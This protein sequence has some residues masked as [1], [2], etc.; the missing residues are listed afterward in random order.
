VVKA[1][2]ENRF[3][4]KEV[5]TLLLDRRG[6][7]V[8]ITEAVVKAAAANEDNNE[9]LRY[10]HHFSAFDIT[11]GII[12]AAATSGQA[13]ALHLLDEWAGTCVVAKRSMDIAQFCAAA[14]RGDTA[15]VL[16]FVKEGIPPDE[17]DI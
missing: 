7:D 6:A 9:L 2:A 1:A 4:G 11:D 14:K 16:H 15:A 13:D 8:P 5:M 17:R 12:Q 3:N 10:L